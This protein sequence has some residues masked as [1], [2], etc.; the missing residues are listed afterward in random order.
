MIAAIELAILDRLR[1]AGEQGVLGYRFATLETFPENWGRHLAAKGPT[2]FPG[3]WVV[4]GGMEDAGI[5]TGVARPTLSFGLVVAARSLRNET[6]T[7]HGGRP[8]EPGSYQLLEDAIGLLH[9]WQPIPNGGRLEFRGASFTEP[10]EAQKSLTLSA[11]VLRF[12]IPG[13]IDPIG[14]AD[15]D[16]SDF[17]GLSLAWDISGVAT[18]PP[19]LPADATADAADHVTLP[20]GEP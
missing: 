5:G 9:N 7:R 1:A 16:L 13:E 19:P 12:D 8:G 2:D 4:F 20:T 17:A 11:F 15:A 18:P 14:Y 6:A 10:F 3:S